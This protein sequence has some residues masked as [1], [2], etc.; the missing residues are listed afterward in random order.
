MHVVIIVIRNMVLNFIAVDF[1]L[2]TFSVVEE[3]ALLRSS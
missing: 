3:L 1:K 2:Q